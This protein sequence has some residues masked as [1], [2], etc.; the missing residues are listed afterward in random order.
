MNRIANSALA[1]L[2][3]LAGA[4]VAAQVHITPETPI[5]G[6]G[7]VQ[8]GYFGGNALNS[9]S[10]NS[11][12]VGID[13]MF[14]GYYRDPRIVTFSFAPNW[15]WDHDSALD[16]TGTLGSEGLSASLHFLNGSSI[17]LSITYTLDR[18]VNTN[19]T[20]GT[21]PVNITSSGLSQNFNIS[22]TLQKR[23]LGRKPKWPTLAL[24]FGKGSSD[25]SIS[26]INAPS[27]DTGSTSYFANAAYEVLGFRL[28][29]TYNRQDHTM[30]S[31]DLL[32]IGTPSS[33]SS[34]SDGES[35]SISRNLVRNTTVGATYSRSN[36]TVEVVDAPSK[37]NYETANAQINSTPFTR[38]S[39]YGNANYSS[40]VAAQTILTVLAPGGSG[41]SGSTTSVPQLLLSTGR[42]F[43][44]GAGGDY[45][46]SKSF[47]VLANGSHLNSEVEGGV[48]LDDNVY[49]AGLL[50]THK[51]A[52]G[53][54]V[55]TYDPAYYILSETAQSLELSLPEVKMH[56]LIN[57]G[58]GRYV[59]RFGRWFGQGGFSYTHSHTDEPAP[60]PLISSSLSANATASTLIAHQWNFSG[61]WALT[62]SDYA[63][64]NSSLANS[65]SGS[66][67]NRT[68]SFMGQYQFNSGYSI[69]TPVGLIPLTGTTTI[70]NPSVLSTF[71]SNNNGF[72]VSVSY[73]R[74]R[75]RVAGTY[76]QTGANV[77]TPVEL[78]TTS[79]T[80][81]ETVA[82]YK[83]R[84]IDIRGGFRRFTQNVSSNSLLDQTSYTYY[85]SIVRPF[86]IF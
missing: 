82:T 34:R 55:L 65:I 79:N 63:N 58:N 57:A 85:V 24:G 80:S 39:L 31:P 28:N 30:T 13:A 50:Y 37:Q 70:P 35:V 41:S 6:A 19:L 72:S 69:S 1:L 14:Q 47:Q 25:S 17:P 5:S 75:F 64:A 21:L 49:S 48:D 2:L 46:I 62:H 20:G 73:S 77:Q 71:Y 36:G 42:Q 40:N 18:N 38:L 3:L 22:W 67:G 81:F 52:R 27:L 12:F 84:R 86:R 74:R 78:V 60:V 15:R 56:G 33:T 29:A 83:L 61:T 4:R 26:G 66:I 32:G 44:A 68:W 10:N 16:Q 23:E 53:I 11:V 8:F 7:E 59:R 45:Y 43:E 54:M 76:S 51:V 9:G